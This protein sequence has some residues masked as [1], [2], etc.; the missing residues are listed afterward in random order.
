MPANL[1]NS[2][3]ARGLERV[4]FTPIPKKDND[5]ECSNYCSIAFI[6][7]TSKV[8]LKI[9]QARLQ[10]YLN[11]EL[12]D[13]QAGFRKG[14]GTR[15]QISKLHW[16]IGKARE[17]QKKTSTSVSLMMLKALTMWNTTN[18]G[19]FF[20]RWEYQTTWTASWEIYTW[21]KKQ[22]LELDMELC[23]QRSI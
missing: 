4:I 18:C 22:Q 3:V 16:I 1:E 13:V 8:M 20:K 9:H 10:H 2:T 11:W 23:Q 19:N 12:P 7:H 15:D 14:R 21:V 5:K 17:F 6:S